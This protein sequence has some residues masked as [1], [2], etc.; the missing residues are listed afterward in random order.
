MPNVGKG[1]K[2]LA[3]WRTVVV[4]IPAISIYTIVCGSVSLAS[5]LFDR[6]GNVAHRCARA[7]AWLILKTSGV[8]VSVR[9][10]E[11][12]DRSRSY[13]FAANHQSIYDIPIV[14]TAL[15][16]QLR[17]VAK[18]SLGRIPFMGWHLHLAGHLLVDRSR[19]GAGVV[20]K[21]ARLIGEHHSLIVFPEGTRSIDGSVQRF[22][23]GSF[24]LAVEAGIPVVPITIVGSCRVMTKGQVTVRPGA[25][26]LTIH[27]PIDTADVGRDGV[28]ELSDRVRQIVAAA[29]PA[30]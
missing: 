5:T 9:G 21:M 17:I 4:L 1:N 22:K 28:R 19:P 24:A 8:R 13:V 11:R 7:W 16:F 18:Q 12:L 6:S 27:D 29:S 2:D 26:A 20:K 10:L 3:W 14:F 23:G 25:V 30:V 15:P